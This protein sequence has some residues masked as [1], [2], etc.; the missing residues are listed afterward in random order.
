[1]NQKNCDRRVKS[2]IDSIMY[3][4]VDNPYGDCDECKYN[5]CWN[6]RHPYGDG[7]ATEQLCEC[8]VPEARQCPLVQQV[9]AALDNAVNKTK[10]TPPPL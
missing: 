7:H 6:E 9:A 10:A 1:M 2:I 5:Y 3:W 8:R 4:A